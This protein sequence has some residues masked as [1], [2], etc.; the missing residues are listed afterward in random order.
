[1][2][3]NRSEGGNMQKIEA[4]IRPSMLS[5]V[6]D[7]LDQ[8]GYNGLTLTEV[9]GHGQQKGV[10]Q[11]FRGRKFN[12]DQIPKVKIEIVATARKV[13]D[14]IRSIL[15]T[16]STGKP[17]DGKIF[18]YDIREAYQVSSGAKGEKVVS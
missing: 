14:L 9:E 16:A 18:V 5:E 6:K 15:K 2:E 7:A 10:P 4:I 1:M 13:P 8:V 3:T 11:E 17:G 12:Q